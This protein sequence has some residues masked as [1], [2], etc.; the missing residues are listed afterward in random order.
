M[1]GP[2]DVSRIMG[3][4][5]ER[6]PAQVRTWLLAVAVFALMVAVAVLAARAI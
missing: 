5:L 1:M 2:D 4:D 6:K 3:F